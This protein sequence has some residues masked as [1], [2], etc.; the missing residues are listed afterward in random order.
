MV[1]FLLEKN[2]NNLE[3]NLFETTKIYEN[4]L[5]DEES[6]EQLQITLSSIENQLNNA[7]RLQ[8]ITKQMLNLVMGIELDSETILKEDLDVLT[9]KQIDFGLLETDFKMDNNVDF[10][11]ANN[12]SEQRFYELKLAK[13]KA[14]PTMNAFLNYGTSAFDNNFNFFL[15]T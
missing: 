2:N 6:V 9:E 13:S 5:G 1:T 4:G 7:V 3:K 8:H 12:L 14:L 15:R 11:L 10:K